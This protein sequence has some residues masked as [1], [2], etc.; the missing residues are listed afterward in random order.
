MQSTPIPVGS[1]HGTD[2]ILV[3]V[4]R[5]IVGDEVAG[6]DVVRWSCDYGGRH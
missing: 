4:V 5:S 3:V 2:E 6:L 1:H